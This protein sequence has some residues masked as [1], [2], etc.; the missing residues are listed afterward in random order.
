[1][2]SGLYEAFDP[3]ALALISKALPMTPATIS[4]PTSDAAIVIFLLLAFLF[5]D[6]MSKVYHSY[7]LRMAIFRSFELVSI[8]TQLWRLHR[9]HDLFQD[10]E[11]SALIRT[12]IVPS[13]LGKSEILSSSGLDYLL[14]MIRPDQAKGGPHELHWPLLMMYLPDGGLLGI[15][16]FL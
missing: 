9:Q 16:L 14:V 13:A 12:K 1:M 2:L 8:T 5:S 3:V 15:P 7:G 11:L 10:E 4:T 6:F